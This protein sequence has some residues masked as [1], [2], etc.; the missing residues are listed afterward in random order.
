MGAARASVG[1]AG[2]WQ[3]L[4]WCSI[5]RRSFAWPIDV[6][7]SALCSAEDDGLGPASALSHEDT[8]VVSTTLADPSPNAGCS[9]CATS[10]VV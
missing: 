6:W 4:S 7:M 3:T 8:L 2:V 5:S 9:C 1:V 10:G